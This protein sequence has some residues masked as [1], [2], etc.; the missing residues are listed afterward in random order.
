MAQTMNI[1]NQQ[2]GQGVKGAAIVFLVLFFFFF[3]CGGWGGD[4]FAVCLGVDNTLETQGI[5]IITRYC[6]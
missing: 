3:F 2:I 5:I 6:E 4:K 1:R